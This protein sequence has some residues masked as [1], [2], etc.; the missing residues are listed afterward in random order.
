MSRIRG[1][2]S[3]SNQEKG[4]R[5]FLLSPAGKDYLWG[6]SRLKDDFDKRFDLDPLAETWECSTHPN[7]PS[8]VA[9]GEFKGKLLSEV[10]KEHPEFV[11][12]HP[13][14]VNGQIPV[15][16]KFIDAKKDLSVQVHPSDEYA[17][18]HENG[19][20]GKTEMWYVIDALPNSYLVYGFHHRVTKEAVRKAIETG[21][22]EKYMNR[23]AVKKGDMFFIPSGTV[24]AIG[25]G[26]LIAEIQESSDLTYRLYDYNRVDKDGKLRPL[27]IDK[28]LDV[29]NLNCIESPKQP[30][31]VYKYRPGRATQLLARCKY[32]QTERMIVNTERIKELAEFRTGS[33]TFQVLL[34]YSGC[35]TILDA[36]YGT[37]SN[38][39]K[40]DCIFVPAN[41]SLLKI[42]GKAEFL[43][44]K[45]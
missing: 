40:G 13:N 29:A 43:R 10:L 45:C 17:Y 33:S 24:H 38:F 22:L 25:K 14:V 6:G 37:S 12:S 35:G 11:G 26:C 16:I 36:D 28:A 8:I 20:L 21:E 34:C 44:I 7:G 23:V 27:H 3:L 18:I 9:S 32:F 30:M 15:L 41:S 39:F 5:P 42:H 1:S 2:M 31:K 4:N 19:S